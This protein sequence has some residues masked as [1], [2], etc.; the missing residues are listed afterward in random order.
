MNAR[1][2]GCAYDDDREL[3][4]EPAFEHCEQEFMKNYLLDEYSKQKTQ[5]KIRESKS[6]RWDWRPSRCLHEPKILL[7]DRAAEYLLCILGKKQQQ[8][9]RSDLSQSACGC[10]G[11]RRPDRYPRITPNREMDLAR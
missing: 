9:N 2:D 7:D 10:T 6:W 8:K 1:K 5:R 3:L 4:R 11:R